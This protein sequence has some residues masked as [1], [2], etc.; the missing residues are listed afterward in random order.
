MEIE[1]L[2]IMSEVSF[3][4]RDIA[5]PCISFSTKTLKGGALQCITGCKQIR[6][7]LNEWNCYDIKSIEGK[8]CKIKRD[9]NMIHYNGPLEKSWRKSFT[10]DCDCDK[11]DKIDFLHFMSYTYLLTSLVKI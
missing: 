4:L 2:A 11:I 3:G 8:P 1:E 5:V 6:N 9:G 10:K 7:F